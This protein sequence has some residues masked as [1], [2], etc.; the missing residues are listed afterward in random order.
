MYPQVPPGGSGQGEDASAKVA[1]AIP[2][3]GK[4]W[5]GFDPTGLE[6]A[7]KAAREL[8][9]SREINTLQLHEHV[10]MLTFL[11]C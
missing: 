5:M 1:A 4:K 10:P 9:Q 7:A 6:R 2:E 3:E 8:N 11:F